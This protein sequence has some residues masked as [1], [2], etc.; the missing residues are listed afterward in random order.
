MLL[1]IIALFRT[2]YMMSLK[3]SIAKS[4]IPDQKSGM[5]PK[6]GK[7]HVKYQY[8]IYEEKKP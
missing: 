7:W 6:L 4:H 1:F 8:S 3:N 5:I 2:N